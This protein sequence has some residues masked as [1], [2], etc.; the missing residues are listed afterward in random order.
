MH[1]GCMPDEC[2][3]ADLRGMVLSATEQEEMGCVAGHH[4]HCD[5]RWRRSSFNAGFD[6]TNVEVYTNEN[7]GTLAPLSKNLLTS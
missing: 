1:R 2:Q 4:G 7:D 5:G 3:A 6:N